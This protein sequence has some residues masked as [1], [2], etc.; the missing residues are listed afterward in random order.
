MALIG[1]I[2]WCYNGQFGL[3]TQIGIFHHS[4]LTQ[5]PDSNTI[6]ELSS[7]TEYVDKMLVDILRG[8]LGRY[9]GNAAGCALFKSVTVTRN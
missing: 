6:R 5:L 9:E 8:I 2:L 3:K 4:R 7:G 1:S